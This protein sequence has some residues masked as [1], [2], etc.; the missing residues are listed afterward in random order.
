MTKAEKIKASLH[1]T[2]ER[3]KGQRAEVFQLKLQNITPKRK[4]LL[5]RAF[6]EAKWLT[7]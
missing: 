6:L 3:R 2:R 4:A 7:N 1:R 5:D